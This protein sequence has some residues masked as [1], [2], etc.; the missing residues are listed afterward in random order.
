MK[1]FLYHHPTDNDVNIS[2][3]IRFVLKHFFLSFRW[4]FLRAINQW[5]KRN[6]TIINILHD[7][8]FLW[9]FFFGWKDSTFS[10]ENNEKSLGT[11]RIHIDSF[12]RLSNARSKRLKFSVSTFQ[13]TGKNI[14]PLLL[15]SSVFF[16]LMLETFQTTRVLHNRMF[17]LCLYIVCFFFT[18]AVTYTSLYEHNNSTRI[19]IKTSKKK[20]ILYDWWWWILRQEME[21]VY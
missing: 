16:A 6:L 8:L 17:S 11:R 2:L 4:T 1:C 15:T 21:L 9:R 18:V 13:S 7:A 20:R 10:L 12:K 19:T 14:P 5:N 3:H